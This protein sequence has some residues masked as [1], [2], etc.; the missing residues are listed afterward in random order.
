MKKILVCLI[1]LTLSLAVFACGNDT[2]AAP[3]NGGDT[4]AAANPIVIGA[5]TSL[6]GALQ[7]YGE[8]FQRGFYLGLE[9]MTDGTME[10][11]GRPIQVVWEDTTNVPDVARERTLSLLERGVD[12]VTGF[13][14]SGDAMAS[15]ALFEEFQTVAV[16]EP[17]AADAII[18]YPNWN[19][20]IFRTGRTSGQ[21]A[22]AMMSVLE[23][24]A[25]PGST[26]AAI[27]PDSTFGYA[28]IDPFRIAVDNAGFEFVQA[29]FIPVDTTDF[30][31]FLMRI[32]NLAPDYLYLV[33]AGANNPWTQ[34]MELD[35]M[36]AGINMIT[37][38][39]EIAALQ[40]ML[41][42]AHAN[43]IGFCIY[44]FEL[45]QN[46]PMNDWLVEEHKA[47]H[48]A[49]PD[50]FVSGGMAAASAIVTALELTGGD[51][52]HEVLIPTMRGMR[53]PSPTG[54]RWFRYEDHQAMQNLFEIEF[55]YIPGR[56]YAVP[57]FVRVIPAEEVM[58]P[59]M[60]RP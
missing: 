58:N 20:F 44:H 55:V 54:E 16:I 30:S 36:G 22:L 12:I 39:P 56:D 38:A 37:G 14:A 31:P 57:Q 53:F 25:A 10:V 11:A 24:N 49:P 26:I 42:L 13:A 59:I 9:Y 41:P 45:P 5:I 18:A 17:A 23:R 1:V 35:L 4:P 47:R 28:M 7:D 8:Q 15:L 29:E 21:D 19:E 46:E 6:S 40:P 52:N 48:N 60:N 50:I 3:A 32:R 34:L 33:W 27:A 2:P 51:T 43:A